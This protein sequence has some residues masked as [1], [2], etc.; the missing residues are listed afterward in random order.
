MFMN[1]KLHFFFFMP[2]ACFIVVAVCLSN[3]VQE[4]LN[5]SKAIFLV[6]HIDVVLILVRPQLLIFLN[7]RPFSYKFCLNLPCLPLSISKILM[8]FP[9]SSNNSSSSTIVKQRIDRLCNILFSFL[10]IISGALSKSLF[11]LLFRLI[12]LLYKSFKS[13]VA[14]L[15]P[16]NGTTGLNSGGITAL[17]LKSSTWLITWVNKR[18]YKF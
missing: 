3:L 14:N 18:F 11:S 6:N 1:P 16:S 2:F 10:T 7:N 17:K 15:P 13:D 9:C 4:W 5:N 8:V 12:T